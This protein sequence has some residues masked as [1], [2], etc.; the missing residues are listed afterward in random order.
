[1]AQINNKFLTQMPAL[2]IKGNDTGVASNPKDLTVSQVTA[3]LGGV[4]FIGASVTGTFSGAASANDPV[5]LPTITYDTN[6][7]YNTS[8][9]EFTVPESGYYLIT[10]Y[11]NTGINSGIIAVYVNSTPVIELGITS[12]TVNGYGAGSGVVYVSQNDIITIASPNPS[13]FN[14]AGGSNNFVTFQKLNGS[15]IP[16]S[17][18]QTVFIKNVQS[19]GVDGGT[20]SSGSWVTRVLNTVENPQ[21]WASLASNQITL[22]AGT[23]E[24]E[25]EA[26]GVGVTNHQAQLYNISDSIVTL[27]GSSEF[28]SSTQAS[29]TW[30]KISGNFTISSSKIFEIQHQ[31]GT[32]NNTIGLGYGSSFGIDNIYTIVK[33]TKIG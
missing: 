4:G 22:N 16:S 33:I 15:A 18:S 11:F 28:S 24:I 26:V 1:M 20:F 21:T 14:G 23:Y 5:I 6:N 29:S 30:S 9:G 32:T 8:T 10:T 31:C 19:S 17:N 27:P 3:M 2:T 25:A 7:A 13:G 12:P